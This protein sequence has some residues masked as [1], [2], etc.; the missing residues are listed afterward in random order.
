MPHLVP[1][2]WPVDAP[3][4]FFSA[5]PFSRPLHQSDKR[6]ARLSVIQA[7]LWNICYGRNEIFGSLSLAAEQGLQAKRALGIL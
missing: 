7:C 3:L 5:L 4:E 1:T 2:R 6:T